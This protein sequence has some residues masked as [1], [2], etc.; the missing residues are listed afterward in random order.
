MQVLNKVLV[1]K[2]SADVKLYLDTDGRYNIQIQSAKDIAESWKET[3][4][5]KWVL[6]GSEIECGIFIL[7]DELYATLSGPDATYYALKYQ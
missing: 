5:G 4:A 6:E 3:E 1:H 7:S 2:C